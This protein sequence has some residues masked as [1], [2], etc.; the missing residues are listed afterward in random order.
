MPNRMYQSLATPPSHCMTSAHPVP[1][2]SPDINALE[3]AVITRWGLGREVAITPLK[4]LW[5]FLLAW[6]LFPFREGRAKPSP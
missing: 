3:V 5:T 1:A 6:T 2:H 4:S